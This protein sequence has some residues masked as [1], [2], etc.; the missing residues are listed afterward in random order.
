MAKK[1]PVKEL[2]DVGEKP[3]DITKKRPKSS[4]GLKPMPKVKVSD[5]SREREREQDRPLPATKRVTWAAYLLFIIVAASMINAGYSL[6]DTEEK[7][8]KS[9]EAVNDAD[10]TM[11]VYEMVGGER[12]GVGNVTLSIGGPNG[13]YDA[14]TDT[15]GNFFLG[16]VPVGR[17]QISVSKNGYH[18]V[19]YSTVIFGNGFLDPEQFSAQFNDTELTFLELDQVRIYSTEGDNPLPDQDNGP[20]NKIT[21]QLV[22]GVRMC[23]VTT[24]ILSVFVLLGALMAYKRK[25]YSLAM[26]GGFMGIGVSLTIPYGIILLTLGIIAVFFIWKGKDEFA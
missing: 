14:M 22:F 9:V 5:A 7:Y 18:T 15:D 6:V 11:F 4:T 24:I 17:Y 13:T 1:V 20:R 3:I 8:Y 23:M 26:V 12:T 25:R 2:P 19:D 21:D 10:M 16:D